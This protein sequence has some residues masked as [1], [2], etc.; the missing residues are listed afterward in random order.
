[1]PPVFRCAAALRRMRLVPETKSLNNRRRAGQVAKRRNRSSATQRDGNP[2]RNFANSRRNR[3]LQNLKILRNTST[4]FGVD[5][6]KAANPP[7]P[8]PTPPFIGPRSSILPKL[9]GGGFWEPL[10]HTIQRQDGRRPAG[11]PAPRTRW[12]RDAGSEGN[13]HMSAINDS[14]RIA[15][16]RRNTAQRRRRPPPRRARP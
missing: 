9:V 12:P 14:T 15:A 2:R 5:D 4:G 11:T 10:P 1:M 16:A 7:C 3:A 6:C 13:T 8:V